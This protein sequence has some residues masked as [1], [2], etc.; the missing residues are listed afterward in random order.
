V[1][2]ISPRLDEDR[3]LDEDITAVASGIRDGS[4][5]AA[6]EQQAGDLL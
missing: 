2:S 5:V 4:L 1:R 6:V 3:P